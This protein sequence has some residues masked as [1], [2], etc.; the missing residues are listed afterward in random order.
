MQGLFKIK[1]RLALQVTS[2]KHSLRK[3]LAQ[4]G[5]MASRG[6][7]IV[8]Q[9][10]LLYAELKN[11][12]VAARTLAPETIYVDEK[13]EQMTLTDLSALVFHHEPVYYIPVAKMPYNY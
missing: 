6:P 8:Q 3:V 13:C 5:V 4:R 11:A 2:Q 1:D 7:R 9:L 10:L 12:N